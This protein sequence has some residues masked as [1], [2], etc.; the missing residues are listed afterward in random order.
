MIDSS[1]EDEDHDRI[2][3]R[4]ERMLKHQVRSIADFERIKNLRCD[5][6]AV[7]WFNFF[8]NHNQSKICVE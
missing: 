8:N 6:A 1:S 5:G 4:R 7:L 2:R 3:F